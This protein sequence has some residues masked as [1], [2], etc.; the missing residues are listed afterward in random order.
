MYSVI[1]SLTLE[2]WRMPL[3]FRHDQDLKG[4]VSKYLGVYGSSLETS[5]SFSPW[6]FPNWKHTGSIRSW[7][8]L[9][10]HALPC[11]ATWW[12]LQSHE[13]TLEDHKMMKLSA[14]NCWCLTKTFGISSK[15]ATPRRQKMCQCTNH[16]YIT[17][18]LYMKSK[19]RAQ[20]A[21]IT[22]IRT[23]NCMLG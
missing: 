18:W 13:T 12:F 14:P 5:Y 8:I 3:K 4:M 9:C 23:Y 2:F 22:C 21:T 7:K 11:N 16:I 15:K 10:C 19:T 20:R 6:S 17:I 1:L